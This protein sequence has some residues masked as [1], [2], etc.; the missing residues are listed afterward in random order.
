M[1]RATGS[2]MVEQAANNK[3]AA[4]AHTAKVWRKRVMVN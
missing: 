1:A 2:S 4:L 3:Q